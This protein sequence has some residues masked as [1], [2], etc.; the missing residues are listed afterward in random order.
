MQLFEYRH[1]S[2]QQQ[3]AVGF[4]NR[5]IRPECRRLSRKALDELLDGVTHV[6]GCGCVRRSFHF[7]K[8]LERPNLSLNASHLGLKVVVGWATCLVRSPKLQVAPNSGSRASPGAGMYEVAL[9]TR[10]NACTLAYGSILAARYRS[11]QSSTVFPLAENCK[12]ANF[13]KRPEI[14]SRGLTLST[15]ERSYEERQETENK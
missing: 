5:N 6:D 2:Q 14:Q 9:G 13:K 8:S 4:T 12:R 11:I 1:S 7:Q 3:L 10:C 15:H